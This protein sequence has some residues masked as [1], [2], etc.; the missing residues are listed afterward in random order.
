MGTGV[1]ITVSPVIL[2][3]QWNFIIFIVWPKIFCL[4]T[5]FS[6]VNLFDKKNNNLKHN[7]FK[8]IKLL[9]LIRKEI[10]KGV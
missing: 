6:P 10:E 9:V 3:E 4:K 5:Q 2:K 1:S 7:I 8:R